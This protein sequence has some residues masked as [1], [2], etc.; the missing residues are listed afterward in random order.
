MTP[1]TLPPIPVEHPVREP[2]TRSGIDVVTQGWQS[3]APQEHREDEPALP[4]YAST[5]LS[6]WKRQREPNGPPDAMT[7]LHTKPLPDIPSSN[8]SENLSRRGASYMERYR[9]SQRK[10][11]DLLLATEHWERAYRSSSA[12]Q[13]VVC[14]I[15]EAFTYGTLTTV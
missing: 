3:S 1:T 12:A 11:T 2:K 15:R 10:P 6:R 14:D 13:Q 8:A 4:P 7:T 5:L 9:S